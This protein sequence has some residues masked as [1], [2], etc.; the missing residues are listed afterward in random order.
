MI[1]L[2]NFF[3]KFILKYCLKLGKN[4]ENKNSF[5]LSCIDILFIELVQYELNST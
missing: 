3:Y 4:E 5:I 1:Y 2:N